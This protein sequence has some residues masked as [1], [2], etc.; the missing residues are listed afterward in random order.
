MSLFV[1]FKDHSSRSCVGLLLSLT[2]SAC[3]VL[4]PDYEAPVAPQLPSA[5]SE[6]E[7]LEESEKLGRWWETFKDPV[8]TTLIERGAQQNL[9]IEAAGL[10]I[11]QARAALGISD[12]LIFPQQQQING[13]L[14]P[15]YR[16]QDGY[17][18]FG[19]SFD[20]IW[21]MDVWGKYARGIEARFC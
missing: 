17:K 3:T 14:G 15:M 1:V 6:N 11:V 13:N 18:S 8:L 9:S 16:D 10:R 20:I 12:A 19:S 4:G 21:E 5:W 2:L 7:M